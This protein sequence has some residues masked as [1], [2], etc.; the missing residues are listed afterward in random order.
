MH[1]ATDSPRTIRRNI[2]GFDAYNALMRGDGDARARRQVESAVHTPYLRIG[3]AMNEPKARNPAGLRESM[4]ETESSAGIITPASRLD[5]F[6]GQ[7]VTCRMDGFL[8]GGVLV[9][10]RT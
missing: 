7:R 10:A 1:A 3:L 8:L 9:V 2:G 4:A 6:A 5:S